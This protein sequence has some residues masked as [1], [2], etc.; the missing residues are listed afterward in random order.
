MFWRSRM[1]AHRCLR[2]RSRRIAEDPR[3]GG[4][5]RKAG[6]RTRIVERAFA[7]NFRIEA[8]EASVALCGVDNA[9]ARTALEE[10]GFTRVI[11]AGLGR[12]TSDFLAF[13][14]H[15]FPGS[16]RASD[17]WSDSDESDEAT[18]DLPAY[19]ALAAAGVDRCG[20]TRLAGVTVG[21]PFVGVIAASLVIGDLLRLTAGVTC[22]T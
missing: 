9:L 11:E 12:G 13:R 7:A 4:L 20:L 14:T 22:T 21:A 5:G 2:I 19:R 18:I 10:V 6:F 16:R 1:T 3:D 8:N 17:I 15:T